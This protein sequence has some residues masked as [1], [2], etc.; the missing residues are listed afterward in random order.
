MRLTVTDIDKRANINLSRNLKTNSDLQIIEFGDNNDYPQIIERL[1]NGSKTGKAVSKIYSKFLSGQGF[2]NKS[3]NKIVVGIDER[4]KSITIHDLLKKITSDL[5]KN[6]GAYIHVNLSRNRE[7]KDSRLI[8]FKNC[9]FTASD[10]F[11]YIPKIAVYDNWD[12]DNTG[13]STKSKKFNKKDIK[14]YNVFNLNE[15]AFISQ[16]N[17]AEGINNF[18]GQIYFLFLDNE[19]TYPLSVFDSVYLDLDTEQQISIYK[20]NTIRNGFTPKIIFR[21][22]TKTE[23]EAEAIKEK[24]IE[25]TGADG[26][27]IMMLQDEIDPETNTLTDTQ[28]FIIDK[29]ESN[30]APDLFENWEKSVSN[31]IRKSASALPSVLI[32]YEE[33]KLSGTSG[34]SIIQA[35][36][37]YNEITKEDRA[38]ISLAFQEIF[39]N[40]VIPDLKNNTNWDIKELDLYTS[41][42]AKKNESTYI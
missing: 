35:T 9:R 33:G 26:D 7:I 8:P 21:V 5:S 34:E 36:N 22:A 31:A 39:S 12:K 42:E 13:A 15:N 29:V 16:V 37:F 3:I 25:L 41:K 1:I 40:S 11:G 23:E 24:I 18:K 32:D 19:F 20:N 4:G 6:N 30:I 17:K 2:E 28:E 27:N 10:D 38:M 14:E